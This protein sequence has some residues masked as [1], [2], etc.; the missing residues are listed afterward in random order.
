MPPKKAALGAFAGCRAMP[1]K[2]GALGAFAGCRAMPYK[3]AAVP[4]A[5]TTRELLDRYDGILLDLYGVMLDASGALPGARELLDELARRGKPYAFVSNDASRSTATY[6]RKFADIGLPVD[7]ARAHVITSGSLIPGWFAARGLAG[8]RTCVLGTEDS[9]E[10][11]RAGGGVIVPLSAGMEIDVLAVCDDSGFEFLPGLEWAL[12]ACIRAVIARRRPALLLPN[13][14]LLYPKGGGEL[15]FTAGA[16]ALLL[17]AGLARR[18]PH[19]RLVCDRL[20]K[21][22]PHLF[23]AAAQQLGIAPDRLVMIG[24]QLET[25]IA[26]ASAAGVP[27]ALLAGSISRWDATTPGAHVPTWLLEQLW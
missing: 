20:G 9:V 19:E 1:L 13:P 15:G 22:E 6:L 18:F 23:T 27:S 10:F 26:G 25:D 12:S 21:P 11:V 4:D 24:D 14:D 5:I 7:P 3:H 17:E 16:M 2:K 8:A